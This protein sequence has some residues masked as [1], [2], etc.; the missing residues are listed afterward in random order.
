MAGVPRIDWYYSNYSNT[1]ET[2]S[3]QRY[4]AN[5]KCMQGKV[6]FRCWDF[7]SGIDAERGI[8]PPLQNYSTSLE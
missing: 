2:N 3:I 6:V 4:S 8:L 1:W 7:G 5:M